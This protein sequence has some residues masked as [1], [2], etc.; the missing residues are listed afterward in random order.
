M[1]AISKRDYTTVKLYLD[2]GG[3]YENDIYD[4]FIYIDE[5]GERIFRYRGRYKRFRTP[6][7]FYRAAARTV[8]HR[9]RY[10]SA[11]PEYI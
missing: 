9:P 11:D 3:R 4:Y 1:A 6:E 2:N 8:K 7:E 10:R 5:T